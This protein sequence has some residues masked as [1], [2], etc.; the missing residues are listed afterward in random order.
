MKIGIERKIYFSEDET[1]YLEISVKKAEK[2]K[3][4]E[5]KD[6]HKQSEGGLEVIDE[7]EEV[8]DVIDYSSYHDSHGIDDDE[9]EEE[10]EGAFKAHMCFKDGKSS[11][12]FTLKANDMKQLSSLFTAVR[13]EV[14]QLNM[15][16]EGGSKCTRGRGYGW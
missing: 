2:P 9:D 7:D 8:E 15:N 1:K 16:E 5:E 13:K 3:P 12:S 14:D 10:D 4:K 6:K 11:F